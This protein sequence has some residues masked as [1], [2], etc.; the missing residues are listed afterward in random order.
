MRRPWMETPAPVGPWEPSPE[1]V[2]RA[3]GREDAGAPGAGQW[4][5][6]RLQSGQAWDRALRGGREAKVILGEPLL[7]SW[8]TFQLWVF[9]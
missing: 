4:A 2:P 6:S 8:R 9:T 3:W 1:P 5:A 7:P